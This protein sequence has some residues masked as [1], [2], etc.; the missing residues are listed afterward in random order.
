MVAGMQEGAK[1]VTW[2]LPPLSPQPEP[3]PSRLLCK[4]LSRAVDQSTVGTGVHPGV[5]QGRSVAALGL[6]PR[7]AAQLHPTCIPP[8]VPTPRQEARA[9]GVGLRAG[10]QGAPGAT[11][12]PSRLCFGKPS[13]EGSER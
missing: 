9:S 1:C 11:A 10:V 7:A 13:Q 5:S 12:S 4:M 2:G 6:A 8:L 3:V